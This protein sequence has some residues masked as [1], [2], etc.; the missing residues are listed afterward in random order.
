MIEALAADYHVAGL[1][2]QPSPDWLPDSASWYEANLLEP[3]SLRDLPGDWFATIHLAGITVPSAFGDES[4]VEQNVKMTR[5][6]LEFIE[7]D[8]FLLASS[9][10]VYSPTKEPVSESSKV[11]PQGPYGRSKALCEEVVRSFSG[12]LKVRIARPFNHIG[13]GMQPALAIPS[14]LRRVA[15]ARGST[16]PI[17]MLGRDSVRDFVDVRDVVSA[18]I[19]LINTEA[20]ENTFNVCTGRPTS[21]RMVV[22]AALDVLGLDREIRFADRSMSGDDS[23][24]LVGDASRLRE[25]T[26]WK[27]NYCLEDSIADM[28]SINA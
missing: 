6:L 13:P 10:L 3:E 26:G 24:Y 11:G 1:G 2:Q 16:G 8:R 19:R 12:R 17:D 22:Q 14:I 7:T 28:V 25:L 5:N 27:P 18:Y 9:A 4:A 15:S 21:I 20:G 23:D